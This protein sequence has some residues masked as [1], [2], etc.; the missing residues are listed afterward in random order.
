VNNR[1]RTAQRSTPVLPARAGEIAVKKKKAMTEASGAASTA[2]SS[3]EGESN[4]PQGAWEVVVGLQKST[5][6]IRREPFER[7]KGRSTPR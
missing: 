3:R 6:R 1:P 2:C 5:G 4:N 7:P